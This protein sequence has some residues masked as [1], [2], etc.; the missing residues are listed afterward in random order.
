MSSQID[1]L[2]A[3]DE[4]DD[5]VARIIEDGARMMFMPR[6]LLPPGVSEG[7]MLSVS[8]SEEPGGS[9]QIT[10]AFDETATRSAR[11]GTGNA[12][13]RALAASRKQDSGGDV[14]L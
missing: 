14:S 12:L 11:A 6:Y 7:Q 5:D 9:V 3:V 8:R 1:H 13:A 4:L 10:V 2:W